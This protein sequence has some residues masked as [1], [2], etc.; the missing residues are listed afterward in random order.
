MLH[1]SLF[2]RQP[3]DESQTAREVLRKV[4]KVLI[5]GIVFVWLFPAHAFGVSAFTSASGTVQSDDAFGRAW[6]EYIVRNAG[7]VTETEKIKAVYDWYTRNME[8]DYDLAAYLRSL[9]AGERA[10]KMPGQD[11]L[12]VPVSVTDYVVGKSETKPR[13]LC[14]GYVHGVAGSLR[15]LGI[16]VMIE[17]GKIPQTA[18]KGAAYFDANGRERISAGR[19]ETPHRYYN[20]RWIKISDLHAR[21]L[22]LNESEGRWISADPTF[23]SIDGGCAYFDMSA[24]KSAEHDWTSLYISSERAPASKQK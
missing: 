21:L 17:I 20:G 11:Y 24:E 14:G 19:G 3:Q 16:P 22:I 4:K 6:A 8:Y 12:S 10:S 9:P 15:A 18:R 23:D 5:V 1:Q 7:A 2:H 13:R